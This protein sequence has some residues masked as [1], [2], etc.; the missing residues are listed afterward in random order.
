[1]QKSDMEKATDKYITALQKTEEYINYS[2]SKRTAQ[3]DPALWQQLCDYRRKRY[4]F[5]NLTSTE[6]LFDRVDAFERDYREWKKDP[7]VT[8]F[9]DAELAF[10]RMM[11]EVNLRVVEAMDFE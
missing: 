5:Q 1:M 7:R 8:E 2:E 11:Q 10:C 9:L 4:E 6:E 3:A